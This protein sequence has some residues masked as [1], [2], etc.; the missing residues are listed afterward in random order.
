MQVFHCQEEKYISK[1]KFQR[2]VFLL[3][4]ITFTKQ[5]MVKKW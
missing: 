2:E 5:K 1:Y 3:V 4:F